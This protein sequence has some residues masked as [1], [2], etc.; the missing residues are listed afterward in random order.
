MR[1]TGDQMRSS[2]IGLLVLARLVTAVDPFPVPN[3]LRENLNPEQAD[4]RYGITCTGNLPPYRLPVFPGWDP[5]TFTLQE[6]CAKPQY[7][8]KAP[9][10]HLAGWC[11]SKTEGIGFDFN[12]GLVGVQKA[13]QLSHPRLELYCRSRCQ[14]SRDP[15]DWNSGRLPAGLGTFQQ[16]AVDTVE[17]KLDKN[18]W[19]PRPTSTD[20]VPAVRY[21]RSRQVVKDWVE[22]QGLG[23]RD[24]EQKWVY[25]SLDKENKIV[26]AGDFPDW[27]APSPF[28]WTKWNSLEQ[29]E[30]NAGGYCHRTAAGFKWIYFADEMTPRPDW[31]WTNLRVSAA[32][33]TYCRRHCRCENAAQEVRKPLWWKIA[34]GLEFR[35]GEQGSDGSVTIHAHLPAT[36]KRATI[37]IVPTRVKTEGAR[38][39]GTCGVD[40]KRFCNEPWPSDVLGPTPAAT[41]YL[42]EVSPPAAGTPTDDAASKQQCAARESESTCGCS[43]CNS[44][45]EC[46]WSEFGACKCVARFVQGPK[47][48][49]FLG[50]CAQIVTGGMGKVRRRGD[51]TGTEDQIG[52]G[53]G[54]AGADVRSANNTLLVRDVR[55]DGTTA[56]LD[57]DTQE[58][59]ACPCNGSYVSYACCDSSDG[60]VHEPAGNKLGTLQ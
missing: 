55:A 37:V 17:L 23:W 26:C 49:G 53:S 33:R 25:L 7:G 2:T 9:G 18:E 20:I 32:I 10:Q 44:V 31:R 43:G 50:V 41:P 1:S 58:R 56:L 30:A 35:E 59:M 28:E 46:A 29:L 11:E 52:H 36:G 12:N 3:D 45:S 48:N 14:C 51:S 15:W 6:I 22:Q 40:G 34:R 5:N 16:R 57:V 13:W 19:P 42:P 4:D 54:S 21:G 39:V 47:S 8:G 24:P 38:A 27:P 60:M